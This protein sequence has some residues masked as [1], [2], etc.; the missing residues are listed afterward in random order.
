MVQCR[1]R[2]PSGGRQRVPSGP[3][4]AKGTKLFKVGKGYLVVQGGT[5][6]TKGTHW[7]KIDKWHL[8]HTY[9][10]IGVMP[11]FHACGSC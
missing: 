4:K 1:Q 9:L 7:S 3:R 8:V 5:R 10:E 11:I 2:V 6:L